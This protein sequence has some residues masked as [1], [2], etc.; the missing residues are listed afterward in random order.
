MA[1]SSQMEHAKKSQELQSGVSPGLPFLHQA[2]V[3]WA[4]EPLGTTAG[5][6][7]THSRS[8][9]TV[10]LNRPDPAFRR[11]PGWLWE[12]GSR[13]PCLPHHAAL[14]VLI[15]FQLSALPSSFVLLLSFF[16]LLSLIR[17]SIILEPVENRLGGGEHLFACGLCVF[18]A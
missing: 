17:D 18:H 2:A 6:A 7:Q 4:Q 12:L 5:A 16:L 11:P 9:R 1:D 3:S 8:Q 15:L 14:L 13:P 10:P